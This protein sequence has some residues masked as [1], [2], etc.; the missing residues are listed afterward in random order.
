MPTSPASSDSAHCLF[1]TLRPALCRLLIALL[2]LFVPV[3]ASAQTATVTGHA[4]NPSGSAAS[5]A[6]V[7]FS[8]QN[9]KPNVPRVVGTGVIVRQQ[10]WCIT[11]STVDGSFSVPIDRNDLISPNGTHWRID[12]LL[13]GLQQSSTSYVIASASFNLD[14]A[15]PIATAPIVGP[16][17][18]IA[19]TFNCAQVTATTT[20]TCVHNFADLNVSVTVYDQN[21]NQIFPNTLTTTDFNTVTLTFVAPQAGRA[22]IIHGGAVSIATNQPNAILGSGMT[23]PQSISSAFSLT[24]NAPT[25]FTNANNHSGAETFSGPTTAGSFNKVIYAGG[26][27]YNVI[28]DGVTINST[29]VINAIAAGGKNSLVIFPPGT[30]LVSIETVGSF[31]LYDGS[32]YI[33]AGREATTIKRANGGTSGSALFTIAAGTIG[34][35]NYGTVGNVVISDMTF[36]GNQANQSNTTTDIVQALNPASNGVITRNRFTNSGRHAISLT[37]TAA[38]NDNWL[39]A[40]NEFINNGKNSTVCATLA[41]CFDIDVQAPM[42]VRILRNHSDGSF[43]FA[44][45]SSSLNAGNLTISDNHVLNCAGFAIALGGGSSNNAA[46]ASIT[47]NIINCPQSVNANIIDLAL[48][49]HILVDQNQIQM[50]TIAGGGAA[51]SDGPPANNVTVTNNRIYGTAGS[52][53]PSHAIVLGGGNLIIKGN[54]VINPGAAGIAITPPNAVVIKNILIEGNLVSDCAQSTGGAGHTGIDLENT[55]GVSGGIT[56]VIIKGNRVFDDQGSPTCNYG[57]GIAPGGTLTGFSNFTVEGNDVRTN[58]LG[59]IINSATP[60]G[61]FVIANNPGGESSYL[62]QLTPCPT[63]AIASGAAT[64]GNAAIASG[65]C[66][67]VVT[68]SAT[69]TTTADTIRMDTERRSHGSGWLRTYRHRLA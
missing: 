43:N 42:R 58:K 19:Q 14:S 44:G 59:G 41:S 38:R 24:I 35:N 27:P 10:N 65:T 67:A 49:N 28:C 62:C 13:N 21:N 7:C 12:F 26:P 3:A 31:N 23:G 55:A 22:V 36:D 6:S 64:L 1:K 48:W 30:C 39:I 61:G 5:N 25:L 46:I 40:D 54:F 69:G 50:G 68:V 53:N 8:L 2:V 32:S 60:T 51:I 11:P 63:Q 18:F 45:F 47:N 33:G 16:S 34:S 4:L 56:S 9:F 57:I 37:A 29:S 20:W 52:A 15:T 66:A 17:S